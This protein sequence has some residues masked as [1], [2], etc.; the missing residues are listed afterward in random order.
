MTEELDDARRLVVEDEA[1]EPERES[2]SGSP[3]GRRPT[4]DSGQ[5]LVGQGLQV[6]A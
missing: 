3:T 2:A 1:Q 4:Q 5:A 6:R